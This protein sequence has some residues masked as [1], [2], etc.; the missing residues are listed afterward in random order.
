MKKG[1]IY[2]LNY[3]G[4]EI[5]GQYAGKEE[6][7]S[8]QVCGCGHN[9]Y[10]FNIFDTLEDLRNNYYETFSFGK[11]HLPELVEVDLDDLK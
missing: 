3:Q 1:K 5:F 8:C 10:C 7:Y 4:Q 6:G 11:E 2:K 9:A